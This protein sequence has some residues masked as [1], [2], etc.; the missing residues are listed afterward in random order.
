VTSDEKGAF[1]GLLPAEGRWRVELISEKTRLRLKLKEPVEVRRLPGATRA[2]VEIRFPN[3]DLRGRV[4]DEQGA[5]VARANASMLRPQDGL[6]TQ[7]ESDAH[8]E[9]EVRGLPPGPVLVYTTEGDRES[10]WIQ[11]DLEEDHETPPLEIVLRKRLAVEGR[12]FSVR[13]PV[14]GARVTATSP[15]DERGAASGDSSVSGPAG[16]FTVRLS[17]G[18]TMVNLFVL[19]PGFATRMLAIPLGSPPVVEVPME[20]VGG[21]LVFDLGGR[22]LQE[23]LAARTGFLMHGGTFVPFAT[24]VQWSRLQRAEQRDP[25]LLVL[26]NMEAGD[27]LLCWGNAANTTVLRGLDAPAGACSRGSLLPLQELTLTLPAERQ[28]A[29]G[30]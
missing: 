28:S 29:A 12:V 7:V 21:T 30:R 11:A 22:T 27:Y 5:A 20:P 4:V 14:P 1:E 6:S 3:T 19:A 8:G 18:S 25:H 23:A 2:N 17:A 10:P 13:G 26:P 9:F 24:A 16:E 15:L